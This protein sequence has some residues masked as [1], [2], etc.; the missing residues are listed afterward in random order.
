MRLVSPHFACGKLSFVCYGNSIL[1][2][3][4]FI[5]C[6]LN[7]ESSGS[8]QRGGTVVR[9]VTFGPGFGARVVHIY[10]VFFRLK[11]SYDLKSN[12]VDIVFLHVRTREEDILNLVRP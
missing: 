7:F 8:Q 4:L 12:L 11:K 1:I 10:I 3:V 2:I 6:S 9:E 5:I